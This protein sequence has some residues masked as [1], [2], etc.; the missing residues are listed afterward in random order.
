MCV[1][2]SD[3]CSQR[4]H[5]GDGF[6]PHLNKSAFLQHIPASDCITRRLAVATFIRVSTAPGIFRPWFGRSIH[7]VVMG[8]CRG[9]V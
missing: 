3:A 2:A 6:S 4:V 5:T 1:C 9:A 7:E 8:T